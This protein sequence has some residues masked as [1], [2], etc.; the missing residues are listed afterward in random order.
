MTA[1]IENQLAE[2]RGS[3]PNSEISESGIIVP[4]FLSQLLHTKVW[5]E[6]EFL[7]LSNLLRKADI[8]GRLKSTYRY[9]WTAMPGSVDL[10]EPWLSLAALLVYRGHCEGWRGE[11]G[12]F[13]AFIRLNALAK[14]LDLASASWLAKG[15]AVRAEIEEEIGRYIQ[16]ERPYSIH[17]EDD[18]EV[19]LKPLRFHDRFVEIPLTVLFY[20]GPIGRAYLETLYAC[21]LKPARIIRLINTRDLVSGRPAG[22]VLPMFLRSPYLAYRQQRQIHYWPQYLSKNFSE[23]TQTICREVEHQL[24]FSN[25]LLTAAMKLH[26]L[27]RYSECVE[28]ILIESLRD[29]SLK[30]RLRTIAPGTV[31]FTG[32]GIVPS[33]I[34]AIP[35]LRL[36]HVHPGFLPALRGA[37]CTLWS[38]F[39]YGRPSASCF[40]MAPGI[41]MGAVIDHCWLP[42]VKFPIDPSRHDLKT[43]Y[44]AI[45]AFLDPWVRAFSLRKVLSGSQS[46]SEISAT[47]QNKADGRTFHFMHDRFKLVALETFF[48]SSGGV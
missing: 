4:E 15:S 2:L 3:L 31:L 38:N 30:E 39:L 33:D 19:H 28:L 11:S 27:S 10:K 21:G 29:Q 42:Q 18:A 8:V 5:N 24:G 48:H 45:Y 13:Q 14:L 1:L 22:R 32:S 26:D 44:R 43:L 25:D 34:L 20:E 41:D 17:S 23:L 16:T 37:D 35:G 12:T 46:L 6:D 40:F 9:D 36:M 7:F 47:S